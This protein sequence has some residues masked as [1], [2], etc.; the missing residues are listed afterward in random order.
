MSLLA[1]KRVYNNNVV[2]AIGAGVWVPGDLWPDAARADPAGAGRGGLS[3][4]S[5]AVE[6]TT[7]QA[8]D[9]LL[10]LLIFSILFWPQ[11]HVME[12]PFL[13][14]W[15]GFLQLLFSVQC[16]LYSIHV[17]PLNGHLSKWQ[18]WPR[19]LNFSDLAELVFPTW[20]SHRS[21]CL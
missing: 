2:V 9:P 7:G 11:K 12:A 4:L 5:H 18:P 10:L 3:W 15:Y 6:A 17:H 8:M 13:H 16:T 19:M 20:Y 21:V 1:D 14:I